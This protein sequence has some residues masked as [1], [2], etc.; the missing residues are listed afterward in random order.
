LGESKALY[1]YRKIVQDILSVRLYELPF[2][3]KIKQF[4]IN[5]LF[6]FSGDVRIGFNARFLRHHFIEGGGRLTVGKNVLIL[7]DVCL[8]YSGELI[9]GDDVSISE[10]AIIYSHRHRKCDI[11]SAENTVG[12]KTVIEKGAW[13]GAGSF[14]MAGL[15]IGENA[16]IGAGSVVT[17]DVPAN[18]IWAG[19]PARFLKNR[20]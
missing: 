1:W 10:R 18:T 16:V 6:G 17:H 11:R 7:E 20:E 13:V 9:I 19:N 3:I 15:T 4:F 5:K 12:M 2:F 14:V 8:D